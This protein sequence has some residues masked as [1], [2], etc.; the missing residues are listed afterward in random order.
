MRQDVGETREVSPLE[1]LHRASAHSNLETW[2]AFQQGLEG[3]VLTWLH[4][5]PGSEAACRLQSEGTLS[6]WPLSSF[7]T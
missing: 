1:L 2:V 7:G 5:H 4:E 6:H 3:T